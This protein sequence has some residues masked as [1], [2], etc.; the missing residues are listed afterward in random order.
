MSRYR[1]SDKRTTPAIW[2]VV[3]IFVVGLTSTSRAEPKAVATAE[4][5]A[6][7]LFRGS[8]VD[9]REGRFQDAVDKLLAARQ[10][11]PKAVLTYNLARAYEG[12]G[13]LSHAADEYERYLTESGT[14][15][16]VGSIRNRIAGMRHTLEQQRDSEARRVAAEEQ[17]RKAELDRQRLQAENAR[18]AADTPKR[19][20]SP[21]AMRMAAWSMVGLGVALL[22]GGG[23]C[24]GLAKHQ[25]DIAASPAN[26]QL[27]AQDADDASRRYALATNILLPVGATLAVAG[28]VW[29]T[30]IEVR[31]HRARTSQNAGLDLGPTR[32]V[33]SW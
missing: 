8:E 29:G 7:A 19:R 33:M 5:Q 4:N 31:R 30:V 32:L 1:R 11:V 6:L 2:A 27:A 26:S 13:D 12:L 9:Y 21:R 22:V 18:L 16:D 17:A 3:F 24:A 10:L 28:A 20:A 23:T 14:V 25:H 15:K